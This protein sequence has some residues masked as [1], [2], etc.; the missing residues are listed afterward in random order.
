[1]AD[2][3]ARLRVGLL[4]PLEVVAG[5]VAVR[6]A[7][8]RLRAVV[9]RLALDAGRQVPVSALVAALWPDQELDDPQHAL[10]SLM[11]R[12]R[13]ALPEKSVLR[14]ADSGYW[15]DVEPDDVDVLRFER[16]AAEGRRALGRDQP[17]VAAE[18]LREALELWRGE[19]LTDAGDAPYAVAA[20]IR[21]TELRLSATEDRAAA[22]LRL[23]RDPAAL[24]AELAELTAQHPLRERAGAL[25]MR[26]MHADGRSAAAL[27]HFESVRRTVI[28]E[29]GTEPGPELTAAHL[30]VLRGEPAKRR[31]N[32]LRAAVTS[33]VGRERECAQ[34]R[35]QLAGAR[36]VTL[37]GAGGSGKTRL[38]SAIAERAETD[39]WLVELAPVTDP[40][41]VPLAIVEALGLRGTRPAMER[42]VEGLASTEALLVLDNCEHLVAAVAACATEL[43]GRCPRLRVLTTSREALGVDGERLFAVQ[44]LALPT[45][46][47]VDCPSVQLFTDRA[48]AARRD[49]AVTAGN[50][51]A[52]AE[53]CRRLDGLPL[54]IEL[55]AA[56]LRS[57]TVE[58][59]AARLD[60][61]F[62]L[63]TGGSRT[64]LPRHRTL[65][66][67]V[68]ASWELLT[69]GE[70]RCAQRLAVFSGGFTL[71]AAE[72]VCGVEPL[73]A[74]VEKSLVQ[75]AGER[76]RM[77]ETIR[78]YC[79][80]QLAASG[81]ST[82]ARIAHARYLC[83][84]AESQEPSSRDERQPAWLRLLGAEHANL[85]DALRFAVDEDRDLA[86]RL[87]AQLGPLW[88]YRGMYADAAE[89]LRF[90]VGSP[91]CA[92][93]YLL[94]AVLSGGTDRARFDPTALQRAPEHPVG[95]LLDAALALATD[96]PEAVEPLAHQDGWT[97][98]M[99]H[100][101]RAFRHAN[102][103][104]LAAMR[105]AL[106]SAAE[107]FR[108]CGE[109]WARSTALSSLGYAELAL[110][111]L[112][113][114]EA[115][116]VESIRLRQEL[117]P[118]QPA[119]L[120][121][122]WLAQ[123]LHRRGAVAEARARLHELLGG[124]PAVHARLA[125]G[126]LARHDGDFAAAADFYRS[127]GRPKHEPFRAMLDCA[128]GNLSVSTGDLLAARAQLAEAFTT[129]SAT[130]D[131]PLVATVAVAVAR[132][133]HHEGANA[134]EVL[135]AA[136]A[137]RGA[138]DPTDP[139]TRSLR[140]AL[141]DRAAYDR[142]RAL[143]RAEALA[144]VEANVSVFPVP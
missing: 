32:N 33:F 67:V 56:R 58:Q 134:A 60:D 72:A 91:S 90:A 96:G 53:I 143:G 44:P 89:R 118:A 54:A 81:E 6:V 43:L 27:R 70:A 98:A 128:L 107:A 125:L 136:E 132:L 41:A 139:D 45:S 46:G 142:G 129:A 15:L 124:P 119:V 65:R 78:E 114:A 30:A 19:A 37:V 31:S 2:A 131:M 59:L 133:R 137:L 121:G 82:A 64:A 52:V 74:L 117:D 100:L 5:G 95:A 103:G 69:A 126:D 84:F 23:N 144:V 49:F 55:A 11:T 25:L 40:A 14:S 76:Y 88:T 127:I 9:S 93:W 130:L 101:I 138:P 106:V 75:Q 1:M 116:L 120:E 51:A 140:A 63:L 112:D 104:G 87:A 36:L 28:E 24:A 109:L 83:E 13:R 29:L 80:E 97:R 38:A 141:T 85:L 108:R 68:D 16:L 122:V 39:T 99:A 94:N 73:T 22:E 12:L 50:S 34:I 42:L 10:H 123:V 92:V 35:E 115:A 26:A 111:D 7:G 86:V 79:L 21:L 17:S 113:R 61:R 105:P 8:K 102:N 18:L 110:G 71:E 77:L 66:A 4:G 57:L 62:R 20:A 47:A 135:G 48:R 3:P